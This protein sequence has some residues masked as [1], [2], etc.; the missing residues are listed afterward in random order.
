MSLAPELSDRRRRCI[1]GEDERILVSVNSRLGVASVS[2]HVARALSSPSAPA[3]SLKQSALPLLFPYSPPS[4][5]S[6]SQPAPFAECT[7]SPL[8]L[9]ARAHHIKL[10]YTYSP[11]FNMRNTSASASR[12]HSSNACGM[13]T[14]RTQALRSAV[15]LLKLFCSVS[16]NKEGSHLILPSSCGILHKVFFSVSRSCGPLLHLS[17]IRR[18]PTYNLVWPSG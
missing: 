18:L 7:L 17:L 12:L 1:A 10:N 4:T 5:D 6:D 13:E 11:F 9:R 15:G 8:L 16:W 2:K 3:R 14:S